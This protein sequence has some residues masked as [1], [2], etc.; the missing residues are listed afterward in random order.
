MIEIFWTKWHHF[1][2]NLTDVTTSLSQRQ[3]Q[4]WLGSARIPHVENL[5]HGSVGKRFPIVT[6]HRSSGISY[7]VSVVMSVK[8][9]CMIEQISARNVTP[10]VERWNDS[11]FDL[12]CSFDSELKNKVKSNR[13]DAYFFCVLFVLTWW[14]CL[15]EIAAKHC[16][17]VAFQFSASWCTF[18]GRTH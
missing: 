2:K 1:G 18:D 17:F 8:N 12:G 6:L 9:V 4:N 16:Q 13:R 7:R 10:C 15:H 3:L 14:T 11:L 5:F